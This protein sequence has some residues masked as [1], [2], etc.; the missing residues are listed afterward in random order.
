MP[1]RLPLFACLALAAALASVSTSL[2]G[3]GLRGTAPA[4]ASPLV[5]VRG[6]HADV[7][8]HYVP[9]FRETVPH[10]HLRGSC[11]PVPER[12]ALPARDCHRDVRRH[13]V[14]GAGVILHRH[15]GDDCTIR[16]VSRSSEPKP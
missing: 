9:E 10:R 13:A 3:P 16:R 6:C 11:R 4:V 12:K 15:V 5:P 7:Q 14:P 8:R 2:A 1:L